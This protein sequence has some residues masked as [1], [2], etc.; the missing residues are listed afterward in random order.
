M[1]LTLEKDI[2]NKKFIDFNNNKKIWSYYKNSDP[3]V[4]AILLLN[5]FKKL[6]F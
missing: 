2:V 1:F 4:I 3:K 6:K 5:F